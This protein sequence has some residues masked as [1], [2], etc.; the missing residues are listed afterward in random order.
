VKEVES[1]R[2][3]RLGTMRGISG[4]VVE[5]RCLS[6]QEYVDIKEAKPVKFK[7]IRH[8]CTSI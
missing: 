2:D 6:D 1:G 5:P 3:L 8:Y 4:H 7:F